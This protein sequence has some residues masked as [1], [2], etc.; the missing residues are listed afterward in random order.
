MGGGVDE[1]KVVMRWGCVGVVDDG[2][3]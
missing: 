1:V 2:G 3:G